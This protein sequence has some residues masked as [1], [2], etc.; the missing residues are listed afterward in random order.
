MINNGRMSRSIFTRIAWVLVGLAALIF[1]AWAVQDVVAGP[2]DRDLG[3]VVVNTHTPAP[4]PTSDE[5]EEPVSTEEPV[6]SEE[7]EATTPPA[8]PA[9]VDPA[10]PVAVDDD[11]DDDDWD[12]D[13]W[14]DDDWDDDDED[15]DDDEEDWEDDDDD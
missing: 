15:D 10:P 1:A 7:P 8:E 9:P 4:S 3:P 14:D 5:P 12:D 2:D 11:D 13:D 6:A